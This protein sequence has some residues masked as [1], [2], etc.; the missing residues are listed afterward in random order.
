M[1]S[2]G[3]DIFNGFYKNKTILITGHTG[4]KG[5]WLSIWLHELGAKVIGYGLDP[6]TSK[7]NFMAVGLNEKVVD[8]RGDIRDEERLYEVFQTYKPEI[9]FHLAAQPLVR[10]AY[11]RPKETYETNVIGTLNV[12]EC[13]RKT[14]SVKVGVMITTDKCYENK[15]QIWGYREND[16][17]GGHDPY[18]SSKG[19]CELLISSYR[20]SYMDP[21]IYGSHVK[22]I[23]SARAG[24]V[25][26]G[27]DWSKDRLVP[28]CIRNLIG[29][30]EIQI[31]NMES[32]RPWQH[33]LEPLS[34]YLSL[35]LK[36][37]E[38]GVDYCSGWNFGP[39]NN[40]TVKVSK[41]C[42]LIVDYWGSGKW[43]N[44]HNNDIF[45]EA[46]LLS[47]DCTKAKSNLGWK[48]KLS[49]EKS[50]ELTIEWYKNYIIKNKNM[51]ELCVEQIFLYCGI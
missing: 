36:M 13:I 22:S 32:V 10:L 51:Y 42:E 47:L 9:V 50:V 40:S 26:G 21:K 41:I 30:K 7:D 29:H 17:M 5:S 27:G 14:R 23:A 25:I 24:N 8:I 19:C 46:N 48:P 6:Y 15:E 33:V 34:G 1:E 3:V 20:N 43:V 49:V 44:A 28:D 12:L 4:F 38:N 39:D 31:R 37:Y 11:E 18:S 35:A 2:M 45:H 16:P